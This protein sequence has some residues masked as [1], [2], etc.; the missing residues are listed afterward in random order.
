MEIDQ[1]PERDKTSRLPPLSQAHGALRQP[2]L[3]PTARGLCRA[4]AA[5]YIGVSPV[6][7]DELVKAGQMPR[8][9]RI[10]T[11]RVWDVRALDLAFDALPGDTAGE[12]NP[13]DN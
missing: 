3:P 6:K 5:R 7:F 1:S 2:V 4:E 13:W 8:P 12:T 9:K 10:G 11:R